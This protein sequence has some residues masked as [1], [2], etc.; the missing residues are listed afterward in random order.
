MATLNYDPA[1]VNAP[2][3]TEAE[4]ESIQVGEQ[5][6]QEEQATFAGKF[7]SAED[8]EQA[9]IELQKKLGDPEARAEQEAPEAEPEAEQDPVSS[10]VNDVLNAENPDE[11][12]A[13]F[14]EMDSQ[15]V[16][17]AFL[18]ADYNPAAVELEDADISTIQ[19][20]VGG[21]EGYAE[22]MQWSNETFP[23]ELVEGFDQLVATGNRYAIQLAVNGLLAAYQNQNG[24]EGEMLTGKGTAQ[25]ADVF[26]SQA[27]VIQAMND[28]RY[29]SDP[30]YRQDIF[31]KLD[32]SDLNTY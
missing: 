14:A 22:L 7:K 5:A 24:M 9:Y 26:R 13:Q 21:E 6:F 20:S 2:E 23:P 29:D 1:E 25:T 15:E 28:P 11:L 16:A 4:Q 3:F 32:R 18:N 8:L 17:K 27:E 31:N 19:N 10:L 30:A 12:M